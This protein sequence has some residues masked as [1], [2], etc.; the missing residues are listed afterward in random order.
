MKDKNPLVFKK[1]PQ[2][3]MKKLATRGV[4]GGDF[5]HGTTELDLVDALTSYEAQIARC[6]P[7]NVGTKKQ[8]SLFE[9]ISESPLRGNYVL[10]ISS[11]PSDMRAKYLAIQIMARATTAW[12]KKHKPGVSPPLWHRVFGGLGDPLRDAKNNKET[13]S[14]LIISNINETSS[15]YKLEKV[16]DLLEMYNDIPR[17]VVSSGEDPLTF[18]GNRLHFPVA[19]GIYLGPPDRITEL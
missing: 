1:L 13:P 2:D 15:A 8:L 3:M 5:Q 19:G 9:R 18:F 17:I 11:F 12:Y 4:S 6:S 7:K 16:R 14:M 10:G